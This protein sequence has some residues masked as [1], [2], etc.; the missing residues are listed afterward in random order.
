MTREYV[1]CSLLILFVV[2]AVAAGLTIVAC[3]QGVNSPTAPEGPPIAGDWGPLT[4]AGGG[5]LAS[6]G[7]DSD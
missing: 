1:R 6:D 3:E 4:I 2:F 5:G 7:D